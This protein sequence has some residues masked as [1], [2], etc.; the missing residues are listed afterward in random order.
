LALEA[1][2]ARAAGWPLTWR[3]PFAWLVRDLL[4]PLVWLRALTASGYEWRGNKNSLGGAGAGVAAI[5]AAAALARRAG[6]RSRAPCLGRGSASDTPRIF[7]QRHTGG[8]VGWRPCPIGSLA[9][10]SGLLG[11]GYGRRLPP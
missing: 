10:A 4:I 6:R 11:P 3:S 9:Q 7:L 8:R 5:S 1:L 2:L